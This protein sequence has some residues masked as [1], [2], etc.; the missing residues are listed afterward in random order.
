MDM[1]LGMGGVTG[2]LPANVA[3]PT[4]ILIAGGIIGVILVLFL[5]FTIG[6]GTKIP[7]VKEQFVAQIKKRPGILLHSITKQLHFYAPARAGEHEERNHLD[8]AHSI[9]ALFCPDHEHIEHFDRL[10]VSNYFTKC[11]ISLPAEKVKAINDFYDFMGSKGIEV[12]E[13]LIDVMFVHDCDIR[14]VYEDALL[15]DVAEHLP[16]PLDGY[17]EEMTDA[18]VAEYN[19]LQ[20]KVEDIENDIKEQNEALAENKHRMA[21]LLNLI[22]SETGE[23][24][25]TMREIKAELKE[26]IVKEGLFVF[27]QVQ[28]FALAVADKNSSNISEAISIA[29]AE[30]LANAEKPGSADNLL[31]LVVMLVFGLAG[32]A[33]VYKIMTG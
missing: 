19:E 21:E 2:S 26:T 31:K 16:I 8:I 1:S 32:L 22:D 14:D 29:N 28:D 30:A 18:D 10:P 3:V 17:Y 25:K 7:Y 5:M 24:I 12:N 4:G 6:V 15:K 33:I 11:P 20:A 13:E 9:G 27:Q 23:R